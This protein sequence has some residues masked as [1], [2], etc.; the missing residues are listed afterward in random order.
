MDNLENKM[1]EELFALHAEALELK[2]LEFDEFCF[3]F[4]DRY[5]LDSS[6]ELKIQPN[7]MTNCYF[8][9][10][11]A[12][13]CC[14]APTY[15]QAFVFFRKKYGLCGIPNPNGYEILD[16]NNEYHEWGCIIEE[17]YDTYEESEL[18][19]LKKLIE[20]VKSKKK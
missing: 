18:E 15:Q 13:S 4:W 14:V 16:K 10:A 19:C 12:K 11:K 8:I 7:K 2:E 1:L 6:I 20:I 9:K 17:L 5:L 3:G